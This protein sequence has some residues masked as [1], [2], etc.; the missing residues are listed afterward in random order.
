MNR[1]N[2]TAVP[3]GPRG[4]VREGALALADDEEPAHEDRAPTPKLSKQE[5]RQVAALFVS[6]LLVSLCA[7]VYQ[8]QIGAISSYL[9]GNSVQQFSFTIGLFMFALGL[10][11]WF[12]KLVHEKLLE[13]L[14]FLELA[15][16]LVG[17]A[18]SYV[19]FSFYAVTR[20]TT[21]R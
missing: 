21:R 2:K 7:I 16:A 19:L 4:D 20:R 9:L 18:T 12:S 13:R 14:L 15:L 17:G 8:L 11:S 6:V 3:S 10:G 1:S 5:R